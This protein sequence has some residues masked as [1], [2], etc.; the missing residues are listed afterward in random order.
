MGNM[1]HSFVLPALHGT[2]RRKATTPVR[3]KAMTR[4]FRARRAFIS[5]HTKLHDIIFVEQLF[6][7]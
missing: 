1:A 6:R 4:I 7:M 2:A 3:I 5:K